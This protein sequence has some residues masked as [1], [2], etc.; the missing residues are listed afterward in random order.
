MNFQFLLGLVDALEQLLAL[1]VLRH[2]EPELENHGALLRQIPLVV[3]DRPQAGRPR[4]SSDGGSGQLLRGEELG[5]HAHD[6]HLLVV[7]AIEDRD[8]AALRQLRRRAPEE[9]VRELAFARLLERRDVQTA[10]VHAARRRGGSCRPYRPHRAPGTRSARHSGRRRRA[11]IATSPSALTS[12]SSS[13]FQSSLG[14]PAAPSALCGRRTSRRKARA[15][16]A[17]LAANMRNLAVDANGVR[18]AAGRSSDPTP[19]GGSRAP[20]RPRP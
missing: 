1:L 7:A 9:I 19:G 14:L 10:R 11:G 15:A 8:A 18:R 6:E 16:D 2:V 5:V 17:R 12:S 13:S 20:S 3:R 4:T